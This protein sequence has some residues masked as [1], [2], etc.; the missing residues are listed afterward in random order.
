VL[1]SHL[2]TNQDS[3]LVN[4]DEFKKAIPIL[5]KW[6]VKEKICDLEM[7]FKKIDTL[8]LGFVLFDVFVKWVYEN[9]IEYH[10]D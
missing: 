2:D 10:V 3:R 7:T 6:G 4:F 1:F 5:E 9:N 8:G